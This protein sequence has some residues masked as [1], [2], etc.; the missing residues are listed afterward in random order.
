M[1][2]HELRA[3]RDR[4]AALLATAPPD[5]ARLAAHTADRRR[6]AEHVLAEGHQARRGRP[7]AR[8]RP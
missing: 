2:K 5:R 4:A 7:R 6:Q 1:R 3:E 8:D